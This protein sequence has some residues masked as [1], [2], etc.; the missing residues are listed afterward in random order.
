MRKELCTFNSLIFLLENY[1]EVPERDIRYIQVP[2]Y[3]RWHLITITD[4]SRDLKQQ[5]A[6]WAV[7]LSP[8]TPSSVKLLTWPMLVSPATVILC[9]SENTHHSCAYSSYTHNT[10]FFH[11]Y[12]K[13]V[14]FSLEAHTAQK[15]LFYFHLLFL[16][17][18]I[19]ISLL[20]W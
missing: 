20:Q 4:N 7:P 10:T 2:L 15:L 9:S 17:L 5:T 1:T 11:K 18:F 3:S 8:G 19:F 12:F 6:V 13:K 16:L 14:S